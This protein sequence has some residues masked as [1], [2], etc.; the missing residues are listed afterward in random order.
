MP[1]NA[2]L[3]KIERCKQFGADITFQPTLA[4]A[5]T[6]A[7]EMAKLDRLTYVPPFDHK[8]IVHGQG[9]AGLE[10]MEQLD[11]FDSVVIPVGGGGYAAGVAT[12]IKSKRPEVFVLG[13]CSD[14]AMEMRRSPNAHMQGFTPTTIADG[15]AVKTIGKVTEPILNAYVDQIVSVSESAI[16]R[17]V[18]KLLESEHAVVEGAGAA[19]VAALMEGMLLPRYSKPAVFVCGSNIDTNLLSRLL[20]H[21]MAETGRVLKVG[22]SLPDRPG[23]LHTVLGIIASLG[24]NVLQV[25]HDRFYARLPGY[26]DITVVMEVRDRAHGLSVIAEL[27]KT[28]MPTQAL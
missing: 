2:P 27:T 6:Y 3:V 16:A 20:E 8:Y 23:M 13:V 17:A 22:V 21:H 10:L 28:G 11:D 12:A 26:V 19:G 25:T 7:Q 24:A 14:W 4:E 9:V 15:I 18:I 5:L 1:S